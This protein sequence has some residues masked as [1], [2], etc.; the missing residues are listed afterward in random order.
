MSY[1][2]LTHALF[3]R[4]SFTMEMGR[5]IDFLAE[6]AKAQHQSEQ[7]NGTI[8]NL[9]HTVESEVMENALLHYNAL[10]KRTDDL[11]RE[12]FTESELDALYDLQTRG[13][14]ILGRFSQFGI[15]WSH[16]FA[17][18]LRSTIRGVVRKANDGDYD[19]LPETL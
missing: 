18:S 19:N 12:R 3:P 14:N 2:N 5:T 1:H 16:S 6:R 9:M 13:E 17:E 15:A 10:L 11:L 7:V 4:A 8:D